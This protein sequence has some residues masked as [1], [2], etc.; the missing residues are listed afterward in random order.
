MTIAPAEIEALLRTHPGVADAAVIGV[1][2]EK[3]G[4]QVCAVV[5]RRPG[6]QPSADELVALCARHL[7]GFKKP[8]IVEFVDELPRTA[9]GKPQTFVLRARLG[10]AAS[11]RA[12]AA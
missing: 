12:G 3:W 11:A 10:S 2:H 1:P 5:E 7:A 4:E 9:S 6:A 8:S